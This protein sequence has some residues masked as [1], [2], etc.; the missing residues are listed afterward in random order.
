M[1]RVV[2]DS[3]LR[4]ERFNATYFIARDHPAPDRLKSKLDDTVQQDLAEALRTAMFHSSSSADQSVWLI[5]LLDVDV[6]INAGW[7]RERLAN[8]WAKQI[9]RSL[10]VNLRSDADSQ[11]VIRFPNRTAY[12][13]A[14]LNDLANSSATGKWYYQNFD[15]L[16]LLP[17]SAS[18]RT[19]IC[20]DG[21]EGLRAL[22]AL[23]NYQLN[24]ILRSI[25]SR[26]AQRVLERLM[27]VGNPTSNEDA[28]L[29]VLLT[30]CREAR[31]YHLKTLEEP[32][33]ALGLCL[34]VCRIHV[35]LMTPTLTRV[36][37][38]LV[39]L[40]SL[41]ENAHANDRD[42]LIAAVTSKDITT[43]YRYL[44]S[45]DAETLLPLTRCQPDQVHELALTLLESRTEVA[46][47]SKTP[48][49]RY[50][51]FGGVFLL[52]P[53]L[54]AMPID[55]ATEGWPT[56]SQTTAASIVRFVV[57]MHC[58]GRT[59]ASNLFADAL[60]RDVMNIPPT[61]SSEKLI[62]WQNEVKGQQLRSLNRMLEQW[63][64]PATQELTLSA[65]DAVVRRTRIAKNAAY[66]SLGT[67]RFSK[68]FARVMHV[69]AQNLLRNF[70]RK[71]PGFS[72]SGFAYLYSNFLDFP[73]TLEDEPTR[74][75][76]TLG[77]P[78]LNLILNMSGLNRGSYQLSFTGE[79]AFALFEQ[80]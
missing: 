68:P 54:D 3:R 69:A 1:S 10:T 46:L 25:S 2:N 19:A 9:E 41:L 42:K 36:A 78:P 16:R 34:A 47:A 70:A 24:A 17:L 67:F 73:A 60:I 79:R 66:L 64:H 38:S 15:G 65:S 23:E 18:L 22:L 74:R 55:E 33:D 63:T 44:G 61:L 26:D 57:V 49:L 71:L 35:E 4:V 37:T 6:D 48:G 14:F 59:R 58:C 32:N 13:A 7:N 5:R 31:P 62:E 40:R 52:L 80:G 50:T 11:N 28:C 45:A 27:E 53:I 51:Q 77:R 20:D 75:V 72:T 30:V 21:N 56:L 29:R 43:L 12:L 8:S 39:R 76:I